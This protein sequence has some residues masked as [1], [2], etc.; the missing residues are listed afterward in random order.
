MDWPNQARYS[1]S[2]LIDWY[3]ILGIRSLRTSS[4]NSYEK[5]WNTEWKTLISKFDFT[6]WTYFLYNFIQKVLLSPDS[7]IGVE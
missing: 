1:T 5:N 4:R 6:I 2:L 3:I 7:K